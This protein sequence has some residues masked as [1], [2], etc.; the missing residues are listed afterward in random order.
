MFKQAILGT[1]CFMAG[2]VTAVTLSSHAG[3]T[4]F[5]KAIEET[6][7]RFSADAGYSDCR[8]TSAPD[9]Q[10]YQKNQD[11]SQQLK[12]GCGTAGLSYRLSP[13]WIFGLHYVSLGTARTEAYAIAFEGDDAAQFKVG[14][15]P[16]RAECQEGVKGNCAYG[17]RTSNKVYGFNFSAAYRLFNVGD[18]E[19]YGKGGMY[20]HRLVLHAQVEPTTCRDDCAW[21]LRMEQAAT[22]LTPTWGAMAKWK[23]FYASW[24]RYENI[25]VH[26]PVTAGIKGS[27]EVKTIGVS[28]PL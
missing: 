14:T 20:L 1:T 22:R 28:I 23:Y 11:F 9:G 17:F 13:D 21:T 27:V 7:S 15:D 2:L 4:E 18:V 26:S 24:E 25:G 5:V 6:A 10:Y 16:N 8:Y 19:F 3:K 12:S